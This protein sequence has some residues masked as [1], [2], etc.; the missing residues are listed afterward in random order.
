[1]LDK[2]SGRVVLQV[3]RALDAHGQRRRALEEGLLV[4]LRAELLPVGL[5]A[6]SMVEAMLAHATI[7]SRAI[8][9][10]NGDFRGD[11]NFGPTARQHHREGL[12]EVNLAGEVFIGRGRTEPVSV[13]SAVSDGLQTVSGRSE[14]FRG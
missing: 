14:F 12:A 8:L 2:L 5:H 4:E 9:V 1:M 11:L 13:G 6:I 3:E 7:R 10:H